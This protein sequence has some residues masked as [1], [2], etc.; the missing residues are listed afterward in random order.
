[1]ENIYKVKKSSYYEDIYNI[2]SQLDGFKIYLAE[3]SRT[4]FKNDETNEVLFLN[5]TNTCNYLDLF[6]KNKF[7]EVLDVELFEEFLCQLDERLFLTINEIVFIMEDSDVEYLKETYDIDAAEDEYIGQYTTGSNVATINLRAILNY[8]LGKRGDFLSFYENTMSSIMTIIVHE[9]ACFN[10]DINKLPDSY[11]AY[12]SCNEGFELYA[13]QTSRKL[14]KLM[15]T[16]FIDKEYMR[17]LYDDYMSEYNNSE[18]EDSF[19]IRETLTNAI[20]S[21]MQDKDLNT[22]VASIL[23][24]IK[25][26]L[27]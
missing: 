16:C 2:Y 18:N 4:T 5:D 20:S 25:N 13:K 6:Y 14:S 10:P 8:G 26:E 17:G 11:S 27:S 7:F 24:Q 22:N 19:D 1:M 15:N 23:N 12:G 9:L 21:I 3:E